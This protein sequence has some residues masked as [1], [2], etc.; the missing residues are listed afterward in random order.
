LEIKLYQRMKYRILLACVLL[1]VM[2][3]AQTKPAPKKTTSKPAT[4]TKTAAS[5]ST[6][7]VLKNALDSFSYAMGMS[8]GNFCN[9]QGIKSVNT[10][11]ILK[12]IGDGSKPGKALF[13]DQQANQIINAYVRRGA[14]EKSAATKAEGE[15]FL[16]ENAKKAGV[17][18]LASGLQ[19]VVIKA[20]TD[21]AR[22]RA[23]D[24]VKVHYHGTLINGF[25]FDSSVDRGQPISFPLNEVIPGWTEALQLMTPGSKW[26]L[27]IP[28]NLAY[29]DQGSGPIPG[30]STLIFDVELLQINRTNTN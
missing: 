10:S 8:L 25:V 22:P 9:Q 30:G 5:G 19:Y 13:S 1:S 29:G 17:V 16:A 28:S 20:G 11:M 26:R 15:K 12:G 24:T 14:I 3:N 18:T 4:S 23:I 2:A 6:A 7:P 27:F 21:T